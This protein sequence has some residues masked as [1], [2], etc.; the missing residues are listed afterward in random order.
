MNASTTNPATAAQAVASVPLIPRDALYG[1]PTRQAGQVSPDGEWLSWLAPHEGVMNVWLAPASDPN[2][3][4]RMTSST[5]RPIPQYFWAPDSG[6]LLYVQDKGGDEN[7]LLYQVDVETGEERTLTPFENTRVSIVGSSNTIKDKVLIGLNNRDPRF[8]DVYLLDLNSG[9]LE[10]VL[11][12]NAYAGFLAD[13][14][15]TLR[16][17]LQQNAAGGTDMFEITDGEVAETPREST[18]MED[19]LTTSVAG[20]T[21]DGKTLYWLDSRGRDTA[22]LIAENTETGEKRIIAESDKAD[23]GGTMSDTKTGEV[24]AYSVYYTTNEWTFL[25]P[26]IEAAYN[27]LDERLEGDFG[28]QSRTED[29]TKWVVWNDPLVEPS[30]VYLYDRPAAT[31]TEFYATRPELVGAPLQPMHPLEIKARD[32]LTLVSYLTLPPESD[33]DADGVPSE[34]VPMVLLVHGGPWARDGYGFN[35]AHQWLANRGYAV[36]SVNFR[37]S[38]GFGKNFINAGNLEWA[39]TM[40][41]DLIDAVNWAVDKG[42]A[43]KDNVAIM[44]GSYGGYATLVGL[45]FT[46]ET[47]ACGVDIVGPSNLETLLETIPPYWEPLVKQFHERMGNPE[48]EEGLA[49]LKERSPLYK[50]NE[51]TKPLLI[52]QGANDPRVK[53]AESD[54][55]VSAMQEAGIPVTYVLFPDEGHGFRRPENNIAFNAVAEN[56]LATCLGGRAEPIGD[57]L[58]KSTAEIVTGA[59]NVQGLQVPVE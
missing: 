33:P 50:A 12:N 42:V 27:W 24:Q 49:L 45:T 18:T 40:H 26:E 29:D 41:D 14:T 11:E 7:Y 16:W 21:T 10:L 20:Y 54:Q 17:A 19:A 55:I 56:F 15:L 32:G 47:F 43:Q 28:V 4:R 34:P 58:G 48:T 23:I 30:K 13:D 8:H 25:D 37:G 46:P 57:T 6:S 53:Q 3:A 5:S 22:A 44:G 31:L 1:N 59:E 35:R 38:T 36:M 9:E 52:G 2:S 51:I 39:G